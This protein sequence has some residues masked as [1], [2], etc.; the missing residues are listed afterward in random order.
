MKQQSSRLGKEKIPELML[1]LSVPAFIGMFVMALYNVIDT[2]YI[3]RGV[4]TLGV[5][6][7][8]I[9]FPIQMIFGGLASTFGVGG[10]SIISR[11]LGANELAEANNVFG[12][13]IWLVVFF[14]IL[15]AV[16]GMFFL[17]PLLRTFGATENI[18]PYA[19][20]YLSII[21]FGSLVQFFAMA[22]NNIARSEGNAKLAML[23]MIISA[24]ANMV[25]DPIF[26]FG[27]DMGIKGA[28]L[29]TIISQIIGAVWLLKYFLGGKSTLE[30][31]NIG[32][33]P[34]FN[35]VKEI[36]TIG[37]PTFIMRSSSSLMV[38]AVNWMLI[39]FGSEI[40]IAVFGIINRLM[41]FFFMPI[42]GIVQGMQPI[43]GFNYGAGLY[44][45]VRHTIKLGISIA[46]VITSIVWVITLIFP[47]VLINIFSADEA[48]IT[49]GSGA[50]KWIFIM[51][52]V[53]GFQMIAG[54]L[55]QT[56]GK[57][58]ISFILSLSRQLLFLIPFALTLP[59]LYGLT[60]IWISFPIADGLAFLF[61]LYIFL[62]NRKIFFPLT[63]GMEEPDN[64]ATI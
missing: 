55:F 1:K 56:L 4:G 44:D 33:L 45:R 39:G 6:G 16:T 59:H 54:G 57:A 36:I 42:N 52:P 19:K 13:V 51:A 5:A 20:D 62:K 48:V 7:L 47:Q 35:I 8:I 41:M 26:I 25:L 31:Q 29:A 61:A 64:Q 38:V 17:E 27:L 23:T 3:A 15:M 37:V 2:I 60:G 14:S 21:L 9:A 18:L 24:S 40:E 46:T 53:I 10:A 58:K 30:L 63:K 28:A 12:H 43:I 11:K 32:W 50:L 49:S 22:T 34:D